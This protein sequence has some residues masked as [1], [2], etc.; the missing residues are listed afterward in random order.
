MM[1]EEKSKPVEKQEKEKQVEQI[2]GKGG[3]RDLLNKK[4]NKDK[5]A[6]SEPKLPKAQKKKKEKIKTHVS[7][8]KK[9]KVKELAELMKKKTVM[10]VSIKGL[11]SSQFQEI[12]KNLRGKASVVVAKKSLINFALEHCGIKELHELV[13]YIDDSTAMVFSEDDAFE[14]SGFLSEN[15]SPAKAKIGQE[16]PED[17]KVEAGPTNLLPGPDISAL[18]AVGL[19]PKVE[20]GKIHILS[21]TILVKK[22]EKINSNKASVLAK[23]DITPF[24][25]GIEPVAAYAGG[26]V[27]G[28]VKVDKEATLEELQ[29]IYNKAIALAVEIDYATGDTIAYLLG[30][31]GG[32]E[33]AIDG[34]VGEAESKEDPEKVEEPKAEEEVKEV[35]DGETK[36]GTSEQSERSLGGHVEETGWHVQ[37]TKSENSDK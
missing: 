2:G 23:L 33:K 7:E 18:S 34:L 32:H 29:E 27:Y 28:D 31:A 37:E 8:E 36:G 20:G 4:D 35:N 14:L 21:N 5:R 11:P 22:G 17:I 26:K 19:Q 24:K 3:G 25:V 10:V 30:K 16:A 15:K 1:E 13:K 6:K 12:K 9:A